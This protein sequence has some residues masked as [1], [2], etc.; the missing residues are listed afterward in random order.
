VEK[1]WEDEEP[2]MS[3]EALSLEISRIVSQVVSGE[4]ID[5]AERGA[6][7]A[8]KYPD[9][10]MS[11][12][13]IGEAITRAAG[14]VGMIKS[15]PKPNSWPDRIRDA[16]PAVAEE[17][18]RVEAPATNGA[19]AASNGAL[20]IVA[21]S[22]DGDLAAAIDAEI[23]NLVS[24]GTAARAEAPQPNDDARP[25]E[26]THLPPTALT[27]SAAPRRFAPVAALRRA[28]FGH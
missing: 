11:G 8:V 9:V 28:F 24:A 20:P 22:I 16:A 21:R 4:P 27:A 14:M 26:I 15:A 5:A 19:K 10:G 3:R 25:A 6:R 2:A 13:M 12:E 7:L 17:T 18:K 23:G 1:L